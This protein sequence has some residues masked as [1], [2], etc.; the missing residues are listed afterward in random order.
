MI[1]FAKYVCMSIS[2]FSDIPENRAPIP[3]RRRKKA[4]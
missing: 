3:L 1:L 4:F 2:P